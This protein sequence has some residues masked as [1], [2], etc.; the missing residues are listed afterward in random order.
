MKYKIKKKKKQ[1][2]IFSLSYIYYIYRL[3]E[4]YFHKKEWKARARVMVIRV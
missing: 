4:K 3:A 1:N 2:M